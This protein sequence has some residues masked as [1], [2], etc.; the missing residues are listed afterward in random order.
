M[1]VPITDS[2]LNSLK[3]HQ[4]PRAW[5]QLRSEEQEAWASRGAPQAVQSC[6]EGDLPHSAA[7]SLA[8]EVAGGVC[9]GQGSWHASGCS[10]KLTRKECRDRDYS[11]H[12]GGEWRTQNISVVWNDLKMRKR[13]VSAQCS[14]AL[15]CSQADSK[16]KPSSTRTMGGLWP[17]QIGSREAW[18]RHPL[19]ITNPWN[20]VNE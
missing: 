1:N 7:L 13:A 4:V 20:V 9:L 18:W 10:P 17:A 15:V 8:T 12:L 2:W 6:G 19:W 14:H 3:I 11:K 5:F 16:Q